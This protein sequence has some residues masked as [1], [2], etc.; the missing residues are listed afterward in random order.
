MPKKN[1]VD[2]DKLTKAVNDQNIDGS[3]SIRFELLQK[4]R[5]KEDDRHFEADGIAVVYR[6]LGQGKERKI[7]TFPA[8]VTVFPPDK[9]DEGT[10]YVEIGHLLYKLPYNVVRPDED[11]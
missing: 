10:V 8:K 3:A 11:K 9:F 4:F 1:I 7:G 6:K 2:L 5:Q